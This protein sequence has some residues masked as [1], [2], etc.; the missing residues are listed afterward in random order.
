MDG[1]HVSKF[2]KHIINIA[3]DQNSTTLTHVISIVKSQPSLIHLA[4]SQV[5]ST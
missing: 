5:N 4:K 2:Y 1:Q 3:H